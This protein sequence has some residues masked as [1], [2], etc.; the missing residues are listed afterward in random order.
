MVRAPTI[1][2]LIAAAPAAAVP[3]PA[4]R[5]DW[6]LAALPGGC[7]VQAASSGGTALSVWGFAGQ[8]RLGFLIQNKGWDSLREGQSYALHVAF[9]GAAAWP[10]EATGRSAIDSEGPGLFFTVTPGRKSAQAGFVEAF[11]VARGMRVT[12]AGA[13]AESLP[14]AGSGGAMAALAQ[15][16]AEIWDGSGPPGERIGAPGV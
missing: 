12:R 7:M 10:V 11:A 6:A 13:V 15:C 2:L 8:Q 16:L 9:D 4:D 5:G 1:A 14:L 3:T